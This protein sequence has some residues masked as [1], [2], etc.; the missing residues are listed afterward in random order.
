MSASTHVAME[1]AGPGIPP[2]PVERMVPVPAANEAVV[3]VHASSIG[4]FDRIYIIDL[5]GNA[6]KKERTPDGGEDQNVFDIEQGVAI[7]IF[8]KK[9]GLRTG[10]YHSELWGSRLSKY[11][12]TANMKIDGVEWQTVEPIA[13]DFSFIPQD[14]EFAAAY[15]KFYSV[16]EIFAPIGDPAPGF[17]TQQ[18]EFAISFAKE[19]AIDKV[20][21]FLATPDEVAARRLF[22]LCSQSQWLYENAKKELP[23]VDLTSAA[24][25]IL[26][27]PLDMRWTIWNSNVAVHRRERLSY[28]LLLD[29]IGLITSRQAGAIGSDAFE[30]VGVC[31][32]P[33]RAKLFPARW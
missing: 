30:A 3:R 28:H 6:K 7:S 8:V 13:P 5:H 26:Y 11:R 18:D 21:R 14:R 31:E 20:V 16:P 25:R 23:T 19:E 17:A 24:K 15:Q 29:N 22:R 12:A 10:V 1:M 33:G 9:K 32:S 27:R 2:G 4:T